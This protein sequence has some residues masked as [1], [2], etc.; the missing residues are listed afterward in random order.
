ML[1]KCA[2]LATVLLLTSLSA[3][4]Q[5][6]TT[7]QDCGYTGGFVTGLG[8]STFG[9]GLLQVGYYD[10]CWMFDLG[11]NFVS[12]E[13]LDATFL[14]GHLGLRSNLSQNFFISY[15]AMGLGHFSSTSHHHEKQWSVGAF[16]GL[17]YQLS[18]HFMLSG[19]VYPYNYE[20]R[21]GRLKN[22]VFANSIISL[23]YVF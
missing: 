11:A 12:G 17:D 18:K 9:G 1:K 4:N 23:F 21:F 16:A 15:G 3:D 6:M 7:T 2:T 13:K 20:H 19:K 14:V 5:Q 22:A 10:T 8:L